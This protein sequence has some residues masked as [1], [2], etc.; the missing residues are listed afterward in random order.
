MLSKV[1]AYVLEIVEGPEAGRQI[2]LS[3]GTVEIGREPGTG[4]E[5]ANDH[6]VSRHHARLTPTPSGIVVE[7]LGSS[8]GTFVNGDEI[9][10]P[11][12]LTP[13]SELTVGVTVFQAR[14]QAEAAGRTVVRPV[15]AALTTIRGASAVLA[16][17]EPGDSWSGEPMTPALAT[18]ERPPDFVPPSLGSAAARNSPLTPLLDSHTK[19]MARTAPLAI[20][21]IVA[22]VVVI[23]LALR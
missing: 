18:A 8:N 23:A 7:D 12:V 21:V 5:L 16:R 13:G 11:A 6:L 4:I 2:P 3:S 19:R 20:F 1:S 10:S 9:H 15:P 14:T 22:L 17:V